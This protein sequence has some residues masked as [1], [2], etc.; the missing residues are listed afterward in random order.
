MVG[1]SDS[2]G[3]IAPALQDIAPLLKQT[4]PEFLLE[5]FQEHSAPLLKYLTSRFKDRE[6][7]AEVAQ[8]A[9]LRMHGLEHPEQLANPKAYLY[10]MASNLAVDRV[11]RHALEQRMCRAQRA[12]VDEALPSAERS[13]AAEQSIDLIRTALKDLPADCRQAFVLHRGRDMSYPEIAAAMGVS[14]SMV[15]KYIARAL[16][17]LRD[18][19]S[20]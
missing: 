13:V 7:A 20:A 17:H 15:E 11:R 4:P 5:L 6:D 1:L 8:E 9:W 14:T 18:R 16:R 3:M 12:V 10:Q 19:L 2:C